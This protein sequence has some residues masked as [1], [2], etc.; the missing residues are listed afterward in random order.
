MATLSTKYLFSVIF[1][2]LVMIHLSNAKTVHSIFSKPYLLTKK[3]TNSS[4]RYFITKCQGQ[5]IQTN[6]LCT[7]KKIAGLEKNTLSPGY[8]I[9][10][11]LKTVRS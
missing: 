7:E 5:V 11:V 1:I 6:F 9:G 4:I 2:E 3:L 8:P 10:Q